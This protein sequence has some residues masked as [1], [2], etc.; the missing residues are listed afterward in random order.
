[1]PTLRFELQLPPPTR[2]KRAEE[3]PKREKKHASLQKKRRKGLLIPKY[4]VPLHPQMGNTPQ[5]TM[6]EWLGTGLQNRLQQ[7]ESAW[8]LTNKKVSQSERL[9][10]FLPTIYFR[11]NLKFHQSAPIFHWPC[12]ALFDIGKNLQLLQ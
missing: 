3:R 7:F 8:Y 12:P 11:K 4:I 10:S 2:G 6:A 9:F 5:G 1:M